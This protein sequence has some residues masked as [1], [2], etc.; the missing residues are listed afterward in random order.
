MRAE[1]R[2]FQCASPT[3]LAEQTPHSEAGVDQPQIHVFASDRINATNSIM[4]GWDGRS[5]PNFAYVG[6]PGRIKCKVQ[7]NSKR[8]PSFGYGPFVVNRSRTRHCLWSR[9]GLRVDL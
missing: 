9:L 2:D 5:A 8:I 4:S 6:D 7:S 3:G 1:P